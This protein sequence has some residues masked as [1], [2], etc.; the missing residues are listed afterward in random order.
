MMYIA[1]FVEIYNWQ[2]RKLVYKTHEIVKV[3]KYPIPKAKNFLD[4]DE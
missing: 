1:A 4:S 3:E 2:S